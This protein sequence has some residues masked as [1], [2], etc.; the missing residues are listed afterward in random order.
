MPDE[1]TPEA[2]PVSRPA[3]SLS[4]ILSAL[5]NPAR[6]AMLT[7]IAKTP[8]GLTVAQIAARVHGKR[9]VTG[10]HLVIL[11]RCEIVALRKDVAD[12]REAVHILHPALLPPPG[13]PLVLEM[14]ALTLRL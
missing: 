2:A 8:E 3:F 6:L 12:A 5:G 11:R 13:T 9:S 7:E 14:G 1:P 10:K 4:S